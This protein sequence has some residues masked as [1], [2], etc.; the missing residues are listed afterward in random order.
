[1][2]ILF[3]CFAEIEWTQSTMTVNLRHAAIDSFW[4]YR[5]PGVPPRT[6]GVSVQSAFGWW[7]TIVPLYDRTSAAVFPLWIPLA[8]GLFA[9]YRLLPESGKTGLCPTCSHDLN[10]AP[11]VEVRKEH[12]RCT[13]CGTICEREVAPDKEAGQPP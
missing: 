3:S 2:L 9:A 7:L 5:G 1:L 8:I 10:G 11:R 6:S 12:V 13:E 4:G